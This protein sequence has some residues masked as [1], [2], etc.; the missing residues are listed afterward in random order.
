MTKDLDQD[1]A[2]VI[3]KVTRQTLQEEVELIQCDMRT[4]ADTCKVIC[5]MKT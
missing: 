3:K 5:K 4:A 2:K 1:S